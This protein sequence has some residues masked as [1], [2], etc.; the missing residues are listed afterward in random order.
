V[1]QYF[2]IPGPKGRGGGWVGSGDCTCDC[3]AV[4]AVTFP[5]AR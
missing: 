1:D 2:L 4:A 5:G 3:K